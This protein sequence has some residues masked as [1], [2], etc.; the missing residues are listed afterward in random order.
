MKLIGILLIN[1]TFSSIGII[2]VFRMKERETICDELILMARIIRTELS[3][4]SSNYISII[5]SLNRENA[6]SHLVFLNSF[7]PETQEI[8][9]NLSN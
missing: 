5:E 6:L 3:F 4:S 9:T 2:A 8:I 7:D 1:I